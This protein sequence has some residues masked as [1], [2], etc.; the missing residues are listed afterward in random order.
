MM[1]GGVQRE[2][3]DI[4]ES[5]IAASVRRGDSSGMKTTILWEKILAR[6][7]AKERLRHSKDVN[8]HHGGG[9]EVIA[10]NASIVE[11]KFTA[12]LT[13]SMVAMEAPLCPSSLPITAEASTKSQFGTK[14]GVPNSNHIKSQR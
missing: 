12:T 3:G 13:A 5:P 7:E 1:E 11:A 2:E 14:W 10:L 8:I 4:L 6:Q 9:R